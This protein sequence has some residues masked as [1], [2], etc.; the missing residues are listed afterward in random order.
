MKRDQ[1]GKKLRR[2][3]GRGQSGLSQAGH[4]LPR[5]ERNEVA[6]W[7]GQEGTP[8]RG[9][10]GRGGR[11]RGTAGHGKIIPRTAAGAEGLSSRE[12]QVLKSSL[13]LVSG[14]WIVREHKGRLWSSLGAGG[15]VVAWTRGGSAVT[16]RRMELCSEGIRDRP[17]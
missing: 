4:G 7:R 11:S 13:W 10:E 2:A 6:R 1:P 3:P 5:S 14:E 8:G 16:K 9:G 15:L 12:A 17:Q